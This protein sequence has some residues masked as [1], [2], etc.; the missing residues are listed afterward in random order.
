MLTNPHRGEVEFD[1]G[2]ITRTLRLNTNIICGLENELDMSVDEITTRFARGYLSVLRSALRAAL[3]G[4]LT[5]DEAGA[6]IDE[7]TPRVVLERLMEAFRLA[8]PDPEADDGARP[9]NGAAAGTGPSSSP[10]GSPPDSS[11]PS[12]GASRPAKSNDTLLP[13]AAA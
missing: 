3:G 2:G 12:S 9:P 13:T 4:N 8:F 1:A 6:I 11:K 10:T 5:L 7:A